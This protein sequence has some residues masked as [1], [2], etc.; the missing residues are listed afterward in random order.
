MHIM[1]RVSIHAL[2]EMGSSIQFLGACT[3]LDRRQAPQACNVLLEYFK[4]R[5]KTNGF[6]YILNDESSGREVGLC[7]LSRGEGVLIIP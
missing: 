3:V 1:G 2:Q 4:I 7:A 5:A 6:P